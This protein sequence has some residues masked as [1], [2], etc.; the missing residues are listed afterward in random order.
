MVQ[1]C[2]T[3][4]YMY[5]NC[6]GVCLIALIQCNPSHVLVNSYGNTL[7]NQDVLLLLNHALAR[8]V[9]SKI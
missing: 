9:S 7:F 3:Y 1:T 6:R 2:S 4:M 5:I 8:V